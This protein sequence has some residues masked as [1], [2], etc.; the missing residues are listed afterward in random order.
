MD[1][2]F[3]RAHRV[4]SAKDSKGV[5]KKDRQMIIEFA[6]CRARTEVYRNRKK[7]N[8]QQGQNS[9]RFYIDQTKRRFELR[10]FADEYI[11][12][13]PNVDFAFVDINCNLSIRYKDGKYG[14]FKSEDELK[15]LVGA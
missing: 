3:D 11:K 14:F 10:K 15:R 7:N 4:G 2:E 5:P 13:K 12:N 1:C 8:D 6:T 9:T